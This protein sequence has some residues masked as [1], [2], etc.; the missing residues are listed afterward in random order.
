MARTV[1]IIQARMNSTRFPGKMS[2]LL[3]NLPILEWVLSRVI[4]AKEIDQVCLAT[5][6]SGSDDE[7]VRLAKSYGITTYRGGE[8]DVLGRIYDAAKTSCANN[9]VRI[10]ADNPFTDPVELDNLVKYFKLSNVDYAFNHQSRLNSMHAD[11][12]GAE[13]IGFQLLESMNSHAVLAEEREH[14][15]LNIWN[16][17]EKYAVRPVPVT[18]GLGYPQMRFDVDTKDDLIRLNALVKGGINPTTCAAD[19]V[20]FSLKL[21][22]VI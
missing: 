14:V 12:F 1:A 21:G 4:N 18:V 20:K 13:I 7:L 17:L 3:G 11:G 22:G 2:S 19:I 15:T 5:T 16:N 10:C 8:S 6:K 9:V